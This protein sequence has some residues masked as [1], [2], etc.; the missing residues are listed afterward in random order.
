MTK[1]TDLWNEDKPTYKEGV[2][3]SSI[4]NIKKSTKYKQPVKTAA[5]K[6]TIKSRKPRGK[7]KPKKSVKPFWIGLCVLL[8]L[9]TIVLYVEFFMEKRNVTWPDGF[10]VYGVD[11]SHHQKEVDWAKIKAGEVSFA[12]MK[13]TEGISLRDKQFE[14]N[15]QASAD[16][17]VVRGAYHFYLPYLSPEK[18]AEHF[19]RT[20]TLSPGDLPPVLDVEVK[21]K[22]TKEQLQKDVKVWLRKVEN[23]YGVKPIIYTGYTFY[24]DYLEGE[25]DD[26]H[27][28]IAHYKVDKL[29]LKKDYKTKLAFWQHTDDGRVD[30]VE[31]GVDCNVFYGS[32]RDLKSL[33]IQSKPIN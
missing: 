1:Q 28:W 23:A 3:L 30:G 31:R 5:S 16:A 29:R 2:A 10:S 21:G 27:L 24:K 26:Y 20:V 11:V 14:R 15:W 12:F 7:K 32:M 13:A 18:Q 19:I 4:K 22:K 17:A 8:G 6:K 25:F 9:I 33:C